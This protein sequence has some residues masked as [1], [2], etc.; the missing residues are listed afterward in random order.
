VRLTERFL[1]DDPPL[2]GQLEALVTHVRGAFAALPDPP[3]PDPVDLVGIAGTSTTLA[4]MK[5]LLAVYDAEVIRRR[6]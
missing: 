5:A 3:G 4:A 1:I 6:R 2:T